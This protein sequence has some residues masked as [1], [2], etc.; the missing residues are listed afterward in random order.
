MQALLTG[1][2]GLAL[3]ALLV[4]LL[5]GL[6]RVLVALEGIRTS[7]AKIAW[8][9]RAI[10]SETGILAAEAPKTL[11]AATALADGGELIAARLKSADQRLAQLGDQLHGNPA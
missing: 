4:L 11:G 10:E 5:I 7:L 2:S 1:L 8:G 3:L 6:T 9:V